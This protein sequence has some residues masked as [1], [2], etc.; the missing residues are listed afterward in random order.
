LITAIECH[1][2]QP[3]PARHIIYVCFVRRGEAQ[4]FATYTYPKPQIMRV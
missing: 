4:S 2:L 1:Y 3:E